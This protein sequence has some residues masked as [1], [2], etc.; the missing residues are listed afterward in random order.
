MR[1]FY[2]LFLCRVS[3]TSETVL[4]ILF[5]AFLLLQAASFFYHHLYLVISHRM[6]LPHHSD[7]FNNLKCGINNSSE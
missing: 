1:I 2:L 4:C 6:T 5:S 3:A 7:T